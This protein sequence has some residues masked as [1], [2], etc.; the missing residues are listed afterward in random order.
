M[1]L[2]P[3]EVKDAYLVVAEDPSNGKE[4]VIG[5]FSLLDGVEQVNGPY[6]EYGYGIKDRRKDK[7]D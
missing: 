4:S 6:D 7:A 5:C 1:R 2:V 3:T